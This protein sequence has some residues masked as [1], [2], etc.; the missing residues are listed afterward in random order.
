MPLSSYAPSADERVIAGVCG[1]IAQALAVDVTLVR[2]VFAL[3]ALAGG[4]GILLYLALWAYGRA[5]HPWWAVLLLVLAGS[6]LLHAVGLS[7]RAVL[8]V[9]AV[10][11][12]FAVVWR[13]GGS[14]RA[15]APLSWGG[16][17]LVAAGAV[18]L[19]DGGSPD[20]ALLA[21]GAVA[22]ALLLIAGPWLWQL[23]VE[24]DAERAARIRS[25]ER[26]E[27]AARVHDSVLQT[28]ALI[29]RHAHEPRRVAAIARRQERELRGWLYGEQPLGDDTS[30]LVAALSTAAADVEEL[31]GVR[32]E[33]ASAGDCPVNEPARALVLAAREAMTN[34]AKF[35]GVEEIDVYLEVTDEAVSLFV[36]DRGSGF[37]RAAVPADRRGVAESIERRL[38]RA[39][40][41]ATVTT[42]PGAGTEIELRLP[43]SAS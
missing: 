4:A 14:F 9:A 39:G 12:G 29:Q 31:H 13:R 42:S 16:L 1:G 27:V 41:S 17:L 3:L 36:R 25:D 2:L 32:I 15:D 30:S 33:L 40:G 20:T 34:A 18:L 35:A 24:R 19:L 23:A 6:A 37:D 5:R 22:G 8:G 38:E 26:S 10:T 7:T 28:L 21:P 11:V 43:R